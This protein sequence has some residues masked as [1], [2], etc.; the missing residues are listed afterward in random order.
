MTAVDD[1]TPGASESSERDSSTPSGG[2]DGRP[3][4][5]RARNQLLTDQ[6]LLERHRANPAVGELVVDVRKYM[7]DAYPKAPFAHFARLRKEKGRATGRQGERKLATA[8]S[9]QCLDPAGFTLDTVE[10]VLL[11][12]V[13]ADEQATK[14]KQWADLWKQANRARPT[15]H[16]PVPPASGEQT[17]QGDGRSTVETR[18]AEKD[19]LIAEQQKRLLADKVKINELLES[20]ERLRAATHSIQRYEVLASRPPAS[21]ENMDAAVQM[22]SAAL[23]VPG[24]FGSDADDAEPPLLELGEDLAVTAEQWRDG[25]VSSSDWTVTTPTR[26]MVGLFV[27]VLITVCILIGY[28]IVAHH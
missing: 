19:E 23:G 3:G 18:L 10:A 9:G 12:L 8:M 6:E 4:A 15:F 13:P 20:R 1:D 21:I 25:G 16:I 26:P 5:G 27:L 22:L 11:L 7:R 28:Q 2:P 14:A 17:Q 24:Y